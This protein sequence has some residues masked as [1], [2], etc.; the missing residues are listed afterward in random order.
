MD[1]W[2]ISNVAASIQAFALFESIGIFLII[3][4]FC[5]ILPRKYFKDKLPAKGFVLL[6]FI[7]LWAGTFH[8]LHIIIPWWKNI[9]HRGFT[10]FSMDTSVDDIQ[11]YEFLLF[12]ILWI[13][14][15][16]GF[17]I[18]SNIL[19]GR[20]KK[21][22]DGINTFLERIAVLA[23]VYIVF[24]LIAVVIVTFRLLT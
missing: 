10:L 6:L 17:I 22:E 5:I 1:V 20:S 7:S 11:Q 4:L 13:F 24:D 15:F 23:L 3:L 8:Y 21:I 19:V 2:E 14:V 12:L 18:A 9:F 16:L